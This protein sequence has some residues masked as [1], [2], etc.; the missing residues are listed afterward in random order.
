MAL[1]NDDLW[2]DEMRQYRDIEKRWSLLFNTS[3]GV[4]LRQAIRDDGD[5]DP[6]ED[7]LRS[8][9]WKSFL[10]NGPLSKA[11]WTR[12]LKDNRAGYSSLRSHFLKYI[13]NPNDLHSSTDPL[14]DDDTVSTSICHGVVTD[15]LSVTVVNITTR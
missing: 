14:A 8:V 9:C 15:H 3:I 11:S 5:F 7:G 12:K 1:R 6:C 2:F 13:D 10:L 4:D